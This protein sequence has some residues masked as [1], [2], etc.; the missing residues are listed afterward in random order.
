MRSLLAY[1]ALHRDAEIS[2]Q[3]IAFLFWP[4]SSESQARTNLRQLLHH[5]RQAFPEIEHYLDI[6]SR[7]LKWHSHAPVCID[8]I[9]FRRWI[10]QAEEAGERGD[11]SSEQTAL[12]NAARLYRADLLPE[13]Y[14]TWIDSERD[15]LRRLFA[16]VLERLTRLLEQQSQYPEAI[17][18][19]R[20]L[21]SMDEFDEST[22][23]LLM[24]LHVL[25]KDRPAA[26]QIYRRCVEVLRDELDMEP[27][28]ET[29]EIYHRIS[30]TTAE[31]GFSSPAETEIPLVG[32]EKERAVMLETWKTVTRGNTHVLLLSGE[33]GIGKTR[34]AQEL[35]QYIKRQGFTVAS[36]S[37]YA[38]EGRLAYGPVIEWFRTPAIFTG[39]SELED[40]WQTEIA[41][42]VPELL[43]NRPDLTIPPLTESWQRQRFFQALA[44][45]VLI[46]PRPLLLFIDNIQ[47]ADPETVEWLHYLLRFHPSAKML[48]V[49]A[50]RSGALSQNG[51]LLSLILE[52][53]RGDAFTEIELEAM[54]VAQTSQ[55]A[56]YVAGKELD[57]VAAATLFAS[58]EGIPLF[59]VEMTRAGEATWD[60]GI[61][62]TPDFPRTII[63]PRKVQAVIQTRLS[64]LSP[65]ARKL[66]E[67]AAT[68]GRIF[69]FEVL[70]HACEENEDSL[71]Q[72]LD[73]LWERRLIR[74]QGQRAYDFSHDKIREVTAAGI[75]TARLCQ[76]HRRVAEAL[77][78]VHAGQLDQFSG[79][80]AVH[81]ENAGFPLKAISYHERAGKAAHR[82]FANKD[83][84]EHLQRALHLVWKHLE[85]QER[86]R[87]ELHLLHV[88]SP[89]LVQHRG[90]T[91]SQ[92]QKIGARV[93]ELSRQLQKLPDPPLLRMLAISKLVSGAMAQAEQ[94]GFQLLTHSQSAGDK[95]AEV[96]AHYVLGVT[97]HWQGNFSRAREHLEQAIALYSPENHPVHVTAYAQNPAVICRIRLALVLWHLGYPRLSQSVGEEALKL[98]EQL[99]HP[100]SRAYALHWYAWLQNLRD[101]PV[102]T[103]EHARISIDFSKEYHFPYFSTQSEILY[104]WAQFRL[105]DPESGLQ[106]MREG[107]SSF[108]ATGS[109]VG[110]S[111]YRA[112]IAEVL[113]A[114]GSLEQGLFLVEEALNNAQSTGE[115]WSQ[116]SILRM[117]GA[118][119]MRSHTKARALAEHSLREAI[120]ISRK[121]GARIDALRAGL[122]LQRYLE[123]G[124]RP[125]NSH[126]AFE[127]IYAWATSDRDSRE[128][129]AVQTL[130]ERW[131]ERHPS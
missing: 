9:E 97:H 43:A 70:A 94:F 31:P 14:D 56:G 8:V 37:C 12:E 33:A 112:S 27:A 21:L 61:A 96:E 120:A 76:F 7:M 50:V 98:A 1:L 68:I 4:D 126:N 108:R 93:L 2:R 13:C 41:R 6:N 121:Q 49:A 42:L 104:G 106:K 65:S 25:N 80:L 102:S 114:D 118:I 62:D 58:T 117:K 57:R 99:E 40:V 35:V 26:L 107:L 73:E 45:A 15:C 11:V 66:I 88:L 122:D 69:T 30:R 51:P 78:Q 47:W 77:E 17:Q 34:L 87:Q 10:S 60:T 103:L 32:R 115:R 119:L 86:D 128:V 18:Y 81:W 110:C 105:D 46:S 125:G 3:R 53:R 38:A 16:G 48:I 24:R 20:R 71:I 75:G 52:L 79:Q 67:L 95:I 116:A 89:C 85:G 22:Y 44:R 54:D 83:A 130:L 92:V 64:Q 39:L 123:E 131:K 84:E 91:A 82:L 90:Y 109:E 29:R 127:E 23:R 19:A 72:S 55:L 113:S 111:Y 100:F 63:L 5:L 74:E 124:N 101:D 36:A 129:Q 28:P 59:I